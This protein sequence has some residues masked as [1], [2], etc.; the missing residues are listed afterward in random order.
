MEVGH[1]K[2]FDQAL[3]DEGFKCLVCFLDGRFGLDELSLEIGPARGVGIGRV[4]VF[5]ANGEVNVEEVKILDAPPLQLLPY[6]GF[7]ALLLVE[8]VP[9]LRGDEYIGAFDDPFFDSAF[10]T[11]TTFFLVAVI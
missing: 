10:E 4:D 9:Q 7:Y 6:N 5:E 11:L 8:S 1:T 2:G 3:I